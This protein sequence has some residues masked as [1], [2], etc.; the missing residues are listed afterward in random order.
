MSSEY[1][2][3]ILTQADI[4][5]RWNQWKCAPNVKVFFILILSETCIKNC[6]E[7]MLNVIDGIISVNG[8]FMNC[9]KIM[10]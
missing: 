9:E 10:K 8:Q 7:L 3:K 5:N 6:T 1:V 4:F 2:I